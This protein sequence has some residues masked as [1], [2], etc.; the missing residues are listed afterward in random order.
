MLRDPLTSLLLT[1]AVLDVGVV[2]IEKFARDFTERGD[3][4]LPSMFSNIH[5]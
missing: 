2:N 1:E 3:F 5:H 4:I